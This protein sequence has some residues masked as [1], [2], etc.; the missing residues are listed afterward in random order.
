[1]CSFS[2]WL[3]RLLTLWLI[4]S[5][6]GAQERLDKVVLQLRWVN[7][8]QFAGYYAAAEKGFYARAGLEVEIRPAGPGRPRPLDE[9]LAGH[10]QYGIGNSGLI[11]SYEN[12]DPVV[13]L[14]S[15]FQRSANEWITLQDSGIKSIHELAEKRLMMTVGPENAELLAIFANEGIRLD[16]LKIVPS[17][18][19]I[20]DLIEGK[21]DAFN[22]YATNEP[23]VL[24][25]AHIAYRVFNPHDFGIDFYSDVLFTSVAEAT[26]HPKRVEA[27]RQASFE[28]WRYALEHPEE[29]ADLILNRYGT[30]K[31]REHLLFEAAEIRKLMQPDLIQVGHMNPERW[32]Q[33]R[34]TYVR[35]GMSRA[36]R[37][38]EDFLF[39]LPAPDL[40][41]L[42]WSAGVLL[43][44]T[45]GSLGGVLVV[46]RFNLRLKREIAEREAAQQALARSTRQL[47]EANRLA[48][49]G[50][51]S[52]D[53]PSDT[54][55]WSVEVFE[56]YG[57]DPA[58][59]P[60]V[61]PEV[62]KYFTPESWALLGHAV[63]QCLAD[64]LPYACDAE[65]IRPDGRHLFITAR[66][67]GVRDAEGRIVRLQG[68][69]QDIT[70]RK[71]TEQI[72]QRSEARYRHLVEVLPDIA[73]T[74][75]VVRGGL[76]YSPRAVEVFGH[77]IE[78]LLAQPF[79]W[80]DSI[81]P[82]DRA[83][84]SEAVT[85]MASDQT[86]F[87]LEYRIRDA[88]GRWRW[89]LDRSI[90][91]RVEA[92]DVIFDG[93]AID[94]TEMKSIQE[95]L[96]QHRHHL[97]L[98]VEERTRELEQAK[99]QAEA[100]NVA[101]SAF[102]ANMSHEIR[103]PL[104][105]ITGMAYM[106]RRTGL[107]D[108][109]ADKLDK[110]ESA[111]RHLLEIINAVLD[112]SKIE[113]GKFH[114][115]EEP[116]RL[117]EVVNTVIDMVKSHARAKGLELRIEVQPTAESLLG[118]RVRLQQALL[119]YV[120]N[121]IKF[122]EQG[123]VRIEVQALERS[124]AWELIRFSVSDTGIGIAPEVVPRLFADFEQADN[125]TTRRYGGTGLG[126]A[127]TRKLARLMGGDVGLSS[128]RGQGSTF[129]FTARLRVGTPQTMVTPQ[130]D[131]SEVESTLRRNFSG[132]RVLLAEDNPVNQRAAQQRDR[133]LVAGRRRT[134][135]RCRRGWTAGGRPG[136][137]TRLRPHPDGRADA[138]DGW[139]GGNATH[140]PVAWAQ[141]RRLAHRGDDCQ[142]LCR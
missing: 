18:F 58:L 14:G 25:Q 28:G 136:C 23:F 41:W 6:A 69:V 44:L 45:L 106:L 62:Q 39:E 53:I 34:D 59:K 93:L 32:R 108:Q 65:V 75:S 116:V 141:R 87:R 82:D 101:K 81:H 60:A 51:W 27:F 112:L 61:Y 68:T 107:S 8:F 120:S 134:A 12:G 19:R 126:L 135:C 11:V 124:A 3:I 35:L 90:S 7:Q 113:A 56:F 95:E 49:L 105:A 52:W 24:E 55:Q 127:V 72:L 140:S 38:L 92:G 10:A 26:E 118:D 63:E 125:T 50:S 96:S 103:T 77:P 85:R 33:I 80:A 129:W 67:E 43:V 128:V 121:A 133:P 142:C 89:F 78:A 5:P 79:L 122:C 40:R 119:N 102:L 115:V 13:A 47:I 36:N 29:M 130:P 94:V 66:G 99:N 84:V 54:H 132:R 31:S 139:P 42:Q 46:G 76:Y 21:V 9:V 70:E 4:C 20:Q 1:M 37:P 86:A 17:T 15:I 117:V 91:A 57:R 73:Y 131:E 30:T 88:Q 123:E 48:R 111:G 16:R 138:A 71:Q 100:A 74:Y 98:R 104:N 110:I 2:S 109:Q 22:G 137:T 64:G 83:R 114:L 97:E